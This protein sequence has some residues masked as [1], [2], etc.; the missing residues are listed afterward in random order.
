M[1]ATDLL[2]RDDPYAKS[3]RATVVAVAPEGVVL[4]R[5]VFYPQG[6]G[7][8]GDVGAIL[9]AGGERHEVAN[10]VYGAD[11][12]Q[13]VHLVP[14][15]GTAFEAGEPVELALDWARQALDALNPGGAMLLYTGAAIISGH[16]P[17]IAA[18]KQLADLSV[19]EI[20]PDLFGEELATEPYAE[21]ERIAAYGI[22]LR[23]PA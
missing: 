20:D 7:Q 19:E 23:K 6:G 3:C 18:L 2:F 5:T 15:A 14:S 21:V 8:P 12:S 16:A 17:L 10:T 1:T 11:R 13:V 9:R 4:D 22:V